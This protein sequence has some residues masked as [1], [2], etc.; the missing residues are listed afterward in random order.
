MYFCGEI[1]GWVFYV[2][3][4]VKIEFW[5]AKMYL[6]RK[7]TIKLLLLYHAN[8]ELKPRMRMQNEITE[9]PNIDII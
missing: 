7:Q 6:Q 9:K 5:L 2:E 1:E 8:C 3:L 4:T